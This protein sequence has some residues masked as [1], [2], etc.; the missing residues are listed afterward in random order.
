MI[1]IEIGCGDLLNDMV[2]IEQSAKYQLGLVIPYI[3][4]GVSELCH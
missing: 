1:K 4:I 3:H 2:P